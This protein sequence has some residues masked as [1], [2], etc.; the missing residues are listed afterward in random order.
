MCGR[1]SLTTAPAAMR[2]LFDTENFPN[3]EPRY[4]IAP[5]Q[6]V[7]AVRTDEPGGARRLVALRWGL[8]PHWARDAAIGARM[9][10]ARAETVAEKPS[11]R[12]AFKKRRCLVPAD[13]FYE[14]RTEDGKKQ[15]F[16]IGMQGGGVFAMAGLWEHWAGEG[17]EVIESVTIITTEANEKL[18]PIHPRMPVIL[19]VA[20]YGTWLEAGEDT[21]AALALL[22]PHAPDPMAFYRVG[23]RVNSVANDDAGCIAPLNRIS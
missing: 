2:E 1:F 7:A 21:G 6:E 4:N 11:F 20:D 14:W 12:D 16:R 19:N 18:R 23:T 3:L 13:A 17:S 9:I 5:S 8:V 15:P 10:N 22:K